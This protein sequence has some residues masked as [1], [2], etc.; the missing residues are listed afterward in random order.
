MTRTLEETY[1]LHTNRGVLSFRR[2]NY[3][4]AL[5]DLRQATRLQ[6]AQIVARVNL[7][8]VYQEL[9]QYDA[10]RA[11]LDEAHRLK[12]DEALLYRT[13]AQ[14]ALAEGNLPKALVPGNHP[15]PLIYKL[16]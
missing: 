14:V 3:A 13:R 5:A 1:S 11:E 16:Q 15:F 10:A 4:E 6:P 9:K 7:A 2:Q 8:R 12:P